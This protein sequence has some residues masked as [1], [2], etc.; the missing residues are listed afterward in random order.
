ML[1]KS[2][3]VHEGE[4][5]ISPKEVRKNSQASIRVATQ[6]KN[7]LSLDNHMASQNQRRIDSAQQPRQTETN[8]RNK[9]N[10]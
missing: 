2:F 9:G 8:P 6:S 4:E 3:G 1:V 5:T 7:K 10:L